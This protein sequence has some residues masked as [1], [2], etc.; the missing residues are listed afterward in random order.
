MLLLE[1]NQ[2][3]TGLL[4]YMHDVNIFSA[5]N[6]KNDNKEK[7]EMTGQTQKSLYNNVNMFTEVS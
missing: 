4:L 2:L 6:N 7:F 1:S 5:K 3:M